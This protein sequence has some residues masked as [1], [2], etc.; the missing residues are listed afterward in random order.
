MH[1]AQ[2]ILL[3]LWLCVQSS[4]AVSRAVVAGGSAE[5]QLEALRFENSR[6]KTALAS[7]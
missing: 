3:V 6:L 7:R 4:P 5:A 1:R 2:T